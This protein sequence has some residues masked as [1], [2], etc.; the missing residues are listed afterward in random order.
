M[1]NRKFYL[2][3]W[4]HIFVITRDAGVLFYRIT[5][6]LSL[7]T[8]LSVFTRRFRIK[9]LGISIMFTHLHM[10]VEALDLTQL[11]SFM[12]QVLS[13]FSRIVQKDRDLTGTLFKR[14]FGSAPKTTDKEKRSSLIY[15]YNNPVEKRLFNHAIEDRWTFLAYAKGNFPFSEKLVKRN[16]RFALR[17]AC[18]YVDREEK[19]GRYLHPA[20][21]RVLFEPLSRSE[22][23]QLTDYIIQC[24]AFIC[25]EEAVGLFQNLDALLL[26]TDASSGK[27]FELG[28]AFEPNSDIAYREMCSLAARSGFLKD[29]KLLHLSVQ[30]RNRLIRQFRLSTSATEK[31]IE[32]FLH[33]SSPGTP[34]ASPGKSVFAPINR[35]GEVVDN[36]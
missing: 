14:P 28:E 26:A 24:Y 17:T 13:T 15:L 18:D 3:A 20:R 31:Q 22:Q 33:L 8:V 36:Q 16:V 25:H 1:K 11:R 12:Q 2:G 10:M 7:Y 27:E 5:D 19:A 9:V 30:E 23:E 6:R 29:W 21:L 34:D 4:H 35:D 32:K